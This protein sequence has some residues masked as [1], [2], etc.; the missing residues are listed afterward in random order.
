M[1]VRF[2]TFL[3]LC[4]L[5]GCSRG[6]VIQPP[7]LERGDRVAIVAPSYRLDDSLLTRA[8]E[9]LRSAG[10]VP[11]L[12]EHVSDAWPQGPDSTF[13]YAGTPS[14]RAS[15]LGM[16]LRD[17]SIKAIICARG[18][19]GAIRTLQLMNLS[20]FRSHPKWIVGYSDVT[21]LHLASLKAGVMSLHGN[22]G[23]EIGRVGLGEK[24][25]AAMLEVLMGKMPRYCFP[26]SEF[27]VQGRAEGILLGGN[28]ITLVSLL[29]TAYDSL[30]D[31]D[32]ILFLEEVEESM[33]AID[34][35]LCM[36]QMQ[37]KLSNVKG[38]VFGEFSDCS[39]ELPF[40]SVEQM[41]S[42]YTMNLGI[43]VCYGFPGGHGELNMPLVEGAATVLDVTMDEVS[44]RQL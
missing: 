34:R 11:V 26:S 33:H 16:A 19:Y 28:M 24:G 10:L 1:N 43:P 8:C 20:D 4:I 41:L 18:G 37:G 6:A 31:R 30:G 21:A 40:G 23:G 7:F 15:D 25:N 36:L 17:T 32:C 38:L 9:E 13:F 42:D 14:Q 29:G 2:R 5:S 22:M 3:L 44:L 35:L 27:N 39:A 12:G